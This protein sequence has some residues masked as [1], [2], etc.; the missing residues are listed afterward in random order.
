MKRTIC[1]S[2]L[3]LFS[4]S[5]V[6][7]Q[8]VTPHKYTNPTGHAFPILAWY[9]I[10]NDDVSHA[11]LQELA[12]AGFNLSFQIYPNTESLKKA[13]KASRGTGVK[14]IT[15]C[16]Q[17]SNNTAV[18]VKALRKDKQN[19]GYFLID[20]PSTNH[21]TELAAWAQKIRSEDDSRLLYLNLLPNYATPEQYGTKTYKQ[22]VERFIREIGLGFVSFDHYPVLSDRDNSYLREGYY[23]NL[24]D[25]SSVCRKAEIPFWGFA[26]ATAHGPYPVMTRSM[27]RLQVFSNLA[28]GAQGL[29]Y[30]T[31]WTPTPAEQAGLNY[32]NAPIDNNGKRTE[33]FDLIKELNAE[34]RRLTPVFLGASIIDVAHTGKKIPLGTHSPKRLPSAIRNIHSSGEGFIVSYFTNHNKNYFMVV[35]RD[36]HH[37]QQAHV[38]AADIV[39][40]ILS[41]GTSAP[42]SLYSCNLWLEPGDYLLYEW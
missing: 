26:L 8:V 33:V 38:E 36:L 39:R 27:L 12:N 11:R 32:R 37:R 7:S 6:M 23:E 10:L 28:Y 21:F 20:E 4:A 19:A 34:V 42:A 14:L 2:F 35:N 5:M 24:E 16:P 41:D 3:A 25:V 13:L 29:Q 1:I 9:S 31:Y 15:A 17:L 40:R 30:F 22:Y 18:T